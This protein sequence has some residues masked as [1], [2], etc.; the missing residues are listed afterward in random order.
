MHCIKHEELQLIILSIESFIND[1]Y[2]EI[3]FSQQRVLTVIHEVSRA[4]ERAR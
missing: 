2:L 4:L 3:K 1:S